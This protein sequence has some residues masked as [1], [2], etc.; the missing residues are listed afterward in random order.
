M[1]KIIF[2][3][4]GARSGKSRFAVKLA[5][6][7]KARIAF[8][9]TCQPLDKEMA[10][11]IAL[12]RKARPDSW[13]TFE[14]PRKVSRLL[15]KIGP[16]FDTVII[17]CLTLLVSNLL[18]AGSKEN[19][20]ELQVKQ[21]FSILKKIKGQAIIVSNEV[22]LGIVPRNSLGRRFRDIAGRVNQIGA[23]KSDRVFFMISGL[24]LKLK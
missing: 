10:K 13:Q 9:A 5:E 16:K 11:R 15:K 21:I 14:E 4:G 17:D 24:P 2:I 12:H 8:I 3:S 18:L 19:E 20:I 22:G 23:G 1:G 6:G 7:K